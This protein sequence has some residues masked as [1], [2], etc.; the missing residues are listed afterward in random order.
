MKAISMVAGILSTVSVLSCAHAF[1]EGNA[2]GRDRIPA[3]NT[4]SGQA[5]MVPE[6]ALAGSPVLEPADVVVLVGD[7]CF[8]CISG[9]YGDLLSVGSYLGRAIQDLADCTTGADWDYRLYLTERF[10]VVEI[11]GPGHKSVGEIFLGMMT[12]VDAY[13]GHGYLN[14]YGYLN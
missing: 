6:V 3:I 12:S 5:V 4:A 10:L 11:S 13:T 1:A 7:T 9:H 2:N 14:G 8:F